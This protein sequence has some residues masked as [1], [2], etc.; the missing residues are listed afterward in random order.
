M[1]AHMLSVS[2][3]DNYCL[4]GLPAKTLA[5]D[6][7][8]M[9]ILMPPASAAPDTSAIIPPIDYTEIKTELEQI[10]GLKVIAT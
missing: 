3:H 7:M 9:H 2:L 6:V 10:Q 8:M 1:Y 5:G 4:A